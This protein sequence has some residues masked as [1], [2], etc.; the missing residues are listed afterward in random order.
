MSRLTGGSAVILLYSLSSFLCYYFIILC[1][2]EL[3]AFGC[4]GAGRLLA[5][6][7]WCR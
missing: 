3:I 2:F 7:D 4:S 1:R 6:V 5:W